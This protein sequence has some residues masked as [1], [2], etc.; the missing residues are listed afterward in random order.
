M[1]QLSRVGELLSRGF[2]RLR[3]ARE[4]GISRDAARHLMDR[5]RRENK[6]V[7]PI[8]TRPPTDTAPTRGDAPQPALSDAAKAALKALQ[9]GPLTLGDLADQLDMAPRR[10]KETLEELRRASHPLVETEEGFFIA[11]Q[12]KPTAPRHTAIPETGQWRRFA[13]ISDT[14]GASRHEQSAA[15]HEFYDTLVTEGVTHVF[16]AG[17]ITHGRKVYPGIDHDIKVHSYP[18]QVRHVVNSYPRREGITTYFICG[19]HDF[20]AC[21]NDSE[22]PGIAIARERPDMIYLGMYS[23]SIDYQGLRVQ[24]QHG[25]G[26][27][28]YALSYKAQKYLEKLPR[29]GDAP[30]VYGLGHYHA[31]MYLPSYQGVH[32]FL[33]G[34]FEGQNELLKRLGIYPVPSGWIIEARLDGDHVAE[35]KSRL[36]NY[37]LEHGTVDRGTRTVERG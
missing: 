8:A 22:D 17:D 14:H 13:L 29:N 2:G 1:N 36:L 26:S 15:L 20:D 16:H 6:P 27:P 34:A 11:Q 33:P 4:L 19:N 37:E 3:I 21:K 7:A 9:Q 10:A 23:G 24:L 12:P 35:I 31:A 30:H 5:W 28:S 18:G 32:A 25:A